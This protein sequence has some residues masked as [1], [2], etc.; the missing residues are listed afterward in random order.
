MAAAEMIFSERRDQGS[1]F[2]SIRRHARIFIGCQRNV[3]L[4]F[5][6]L[7]CLCAA[8]AQAA[9][10]KPETVAAFNRYVSA[11]E[12]QMKKDEGPDQ[13]LVIDR[14]PEAERKE[15][16]EQVRNGEA[17]IRELVTKENGEPIPISNGLVHH[18]VGV[19]FIPNATLS[20]TDAVLHDYANEAT[21]FFPQIRRA[22]IIEQNGNESK[23]Y[24]QFYNK[25]IITVVLDAYFD[26]T[27]R[28]IGS[29]RIQSVSH[30]YRIVEVADPG[31]PTEHERTDGGDHGYMWRLCSYWRLEEKDGGTYVE[32][33]SITLTRTVPVM[34]AWII[35]PLTKSIPRDVLQHTLMD[36]R[37]AVLKTGQ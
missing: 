29:S 5:L 14:L 23:I 13:F 8:V 26:V 9:E 10:L 16:Y 17:F 6:V 7:S 12:A 32:N 21:I 25:S 2:R 24:L 28:Q 3:F 20:E 19:M 37:K 34:L 18:W 27:E 4:V 35:N 33:E 22:K 30:S 11:T 15:A 31:T 1:R 36:T